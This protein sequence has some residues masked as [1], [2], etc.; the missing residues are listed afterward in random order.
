L[1][2]HRSFI[3]HCCQYDRFFA[4]FEHSLYSYNHASRA[5]GTMMHIA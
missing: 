1:L 4:V 5:A 3:M 2:I